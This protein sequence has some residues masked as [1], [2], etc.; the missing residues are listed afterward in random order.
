VCGGLEPPA[1][2]DRGYYVQPTV[3]TAVDPDMRIAQ[4]EIFGPVLCLIPYDSE[5]DAIAIANDSRY[6]LAGAVWSADFARAERV[7]RKMR[8][9]RVVVNARAVRRLPPVGRRSRVRPVWPARV[10]RG[11]DVAMLRMTMRRTACRT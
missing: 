9:G 6:G 3:F 2:R 5:S 1:G 7:A 8:T 10:P 11:E 4:E